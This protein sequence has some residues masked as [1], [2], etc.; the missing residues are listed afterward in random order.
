MPANS[1]SILPM[2]QCPALLFFLSFS[3]LLLPKIR[4]IFTNW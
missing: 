2:V 1:A 4:G 3:F